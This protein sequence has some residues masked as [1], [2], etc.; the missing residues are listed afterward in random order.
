MI[1][2]G[3]RGGKRYQIQVKK[4][5]GIWEVILLSPEIRFPDGSGF[6][7]AIIYRIFSRVGI[8]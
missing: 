5:V 7:E 1:P 8:E 3:G 4:L 6:S 2:E